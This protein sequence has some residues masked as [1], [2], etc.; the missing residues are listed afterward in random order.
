MDLGQYLSSHNSRNSE[1]NHKNHHGV[2]SVRLL[3]SLDLAELSALVNEE[4]GE[5]AGIPRPGRV[6]DAARWL[7][8]VEAEVHHAPV[9]GIF[10]ASLVG[11]CRARY[12]DAAGRSVQISYWIAPGF[13]QQGFGQAGVWSVLQVMAGRGVVH[14]RAYVAPGNVA[15]QR[16]LRRLGFRCG[17]LRIYEEAGAVLP[18][19]LDLGEVGRGIC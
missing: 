6:A 2:A 17:E 10:A 14:A 18:F 15:S 12:R 19:D 7:R 1:E 13:R 8:A 5:A 9:F 16:L 3:H 4:C 11:T